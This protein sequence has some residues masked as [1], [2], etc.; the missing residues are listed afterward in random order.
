M[1]PKR[2]TWVLKARLRLKKLNKWFKIINTKFNDKLW[3]RKRKIE[4][5]Q[6]II[7]RSQIKTS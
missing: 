3:R 5:N 7:L 4:W 6:P 1:S 2:S